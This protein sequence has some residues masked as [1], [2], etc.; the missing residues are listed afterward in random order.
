M[1]CL[2]TAVV[3]ITECFYTVCFATDVMVCGPVFRVDHRPGLQVPVQE[4]PRLRAGQVEAVL[5][6]HNDNDNDNDNDTA[7]QHSVGDDGPEAGV[8]EAE[9]QPAQGYVPDAD[10]APVTVYY[11][12]S[13]AAELSTDLVTVAAI[14]A[15]LDTLMLS[16]VSSWDR[17][18]T[19]FFNF[20]F[21]CL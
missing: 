6:L 9:Q 8:G 18:F 20:D 12:V 7:H 5:S 21:Y 14:P 11:L 16:I 15:V 10:A 4:V 1:S 13:S 19:V 2:I 3:E 17:K